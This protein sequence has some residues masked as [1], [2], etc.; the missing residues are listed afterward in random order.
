MSY[1]EFVIFFFLKRDEQVSK[2]LL[3][4]P[5]QDFYDYNFWFPEKAI[6]DEKVWNRV[7][8][9]IEKANKGKIPTQFHVTCFGLLLR[10]LWKIKGILIMRKEW[11]I[12]RMNIN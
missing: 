8:K 7:Q 3:L 10:N 1:V 12:P 5:S 4:D 9:K 11:I 2:L 6:L